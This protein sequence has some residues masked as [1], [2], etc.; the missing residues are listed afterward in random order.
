MLPPSVSVRDAL[1]AYER[2][3]IE[4]CPSSLMHNVL[5]SAGIGLWKLGRLNKKVIHV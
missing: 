1:D 2:E 3:K 4:K 5:D